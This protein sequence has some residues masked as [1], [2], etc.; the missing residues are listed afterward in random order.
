MQW[1]KEKNVMMEVESDLE[2]IARVKAVRILEE[3]NKQQL[4]TIEALLDKMKEL[5]KCKKEQEQQ[6][7]E[8]ERQTIGETN[9]I[10]KTSECTI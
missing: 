8:I 9:R 2:K 7:K 1:L 5:N 10:K 6:Q 3:E 4:Q